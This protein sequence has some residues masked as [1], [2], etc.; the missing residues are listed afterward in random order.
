M[1]AESKKKNAYDRFYVRL[2][3]IFNGIVASSMI[4]FVFIFLQ[5]QSDKPEPWVEGSSADTFKIV[6]IVV[7]LGLLFLANLRGPKLIVKARE[8]ETISE[9]LHIYLGQKMQ[10]YAMIE[11]AAIVSLIALFLI[12]DQLFSFIYL[13]TL[14]VFSM[15]RPRFGR[16]AKEIGTTEDELSQWAQDHTED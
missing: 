2:N 11:A 10:H 15:H 8:G 16:V 7:S 13:G 14:F 1:A 12:K 4:P 9:K 3:L 6:C 5:N